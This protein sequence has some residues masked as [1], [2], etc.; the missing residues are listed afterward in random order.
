[1]IIPDLVEIAGFF[2][3]YAVAVVAADRAVVGYFVPAAVVAAGYFVAGLGFTGYFVAGLGSAGCFADA[4]DLACLVGFAVV[5]V[6][7]GLAV[8]Y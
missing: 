6:S 8:D 2:A 1:M 7:V 3:D 4:V 5:A